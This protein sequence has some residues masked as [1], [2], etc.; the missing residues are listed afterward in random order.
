MTTRIASAAVLVLVVAGLYFASLDSE[1]SP[2]VSHA[3]QPREE[4]AV[5]PPRPEAIGLAAADASESD[6]PKSDAERAV[7][8]TN[9][10]SA[11]LAA[12]S[13]RAHI[14]QLIANGLAPADS[15]RVVEAFLHGLAECNFEAA[16]QEYAARGVT[17]A[18][19]LRGA[20]RL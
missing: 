12:R 11:A 4:S 9:A 18:E 2:P 13:M 20:E 16:R 15:E 1:Q 5:P 17:Y 14:G 6:S 3:S 19:F 7:S 10:M 8:I